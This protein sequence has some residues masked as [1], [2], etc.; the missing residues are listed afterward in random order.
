M[1]TSIAHEVAP[2][3]K[4]ALGKNAYYLKGLG[5]L[6]KFRSWK[7]TVTADG[8]EHEL[9][10][11]LFIIINSSTVGSMKHVA[12]GVQVDDGLLDFL[13]VQK[14][15]V[16]QLM[17]LG[18]D[19]LAGKPVSSREGVLHLQARCFTV[20]AEE[21]LQS[22]LDGEAGPMLPLTVETVHKALEVYC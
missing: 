3:L 15:G 7:L 20:K 18:K 4:N 11:F 21:E 16:P 13:A 9:E 8:Q 19:L 14:T 10:A 5:E 22:D 17:A 12:D 1:M 6:A 2:R